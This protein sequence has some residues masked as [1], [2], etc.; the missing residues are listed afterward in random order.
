MSK[1]RWCS[2]IFIDILIFVK[3]YLEFLHWGTV[4]VFFLYIEIF[5]D[6]NAVL[7]WN[8]EYGKISFFLGGEYLHLVPFVI[9]NL[10][11]LGLHIGG[12]TGFGQGG[13]CPWVVQEGE[14]R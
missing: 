11:S 3:R 10:F 13:R 9:S 4:H 6:V 14:C 2:D 1:S 5:G 12:V 8:L 7:Y